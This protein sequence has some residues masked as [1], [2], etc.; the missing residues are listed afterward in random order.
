MI[1]II[2]TPEKRDELRRLYAQAVD[3]NKDTFVID[4]HELVTSYAKYLLQYLDQ[5]MPPQP[6]R[7]YARS[8][9]GR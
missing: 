6:R 1:T 8:K 9:G 2:W 4:G 3:T 7:T 5:R